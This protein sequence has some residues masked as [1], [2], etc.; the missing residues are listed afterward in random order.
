MSRT[1]T[2]TCLNQQPDNLSTETVK[3]AALTLESVHNVQAS[4]GLALGVL[5]IGDC[6]A[7]DAFEE[8]LENATGLFV[9]H[10]GWM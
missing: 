6:I 3:S 1:T 4:D 2:A 5:G 8:G 10:C 9:D 7:D